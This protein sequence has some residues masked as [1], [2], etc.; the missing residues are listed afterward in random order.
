MVLLA[1]FQFLYDNIAQGIVP[2]AHLLF[3]CHV[4]FALKV[5]FTVYVYCFY[6]YKSPLKNKQEVGGICGPNC[7]HMNTYVKVFERCVEG[8][9]YFDKNGCRRKKVGIQTN[10]LAGL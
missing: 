7:M 3:Y 4:S 5:L 8:D 10:V 1:Q 2:L 9:F 6:V